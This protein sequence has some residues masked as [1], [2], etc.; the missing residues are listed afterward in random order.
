VSAPAEPER[1]ARAL[2]RLAGWMERFSPF[3][4]LDERG[5]GLEGLFLDLTGG[6]HLFGGERDWNGWARQPGSGWPTPLA[7]PGPWPA[8]ARAA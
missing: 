2:S 4:A 3:V 5:D 6:Q 7:P 1:S 8:T